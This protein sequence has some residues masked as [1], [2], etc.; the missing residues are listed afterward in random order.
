MHL[1]GP[2]FESFRQ[3][4]TIL[5]QPYLPRGE[6]N[7]QQRPGV[8]SSKRWLHKILVQPK[9]RFLPSH[10]QS[11]SYR[12]SLGYSPQKWHAAN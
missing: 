1:A 10:G 2:T 11:G 4:A 7:Q 8:G 6:R 3:E 9:P 5:P 12:T